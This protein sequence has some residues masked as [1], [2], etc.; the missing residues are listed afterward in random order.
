MDLASLSWTELHCLLPSL[1]HSTKEGSAARLAVRASALSA[2]CTCLRLRLWSCMRAG[3]SAPVAACASGRPCVLIVWP[4][5]LP[6]PP[7][8]PPPPPPPPLPRALSPLASPWTHPLA[9][10]PPPPLATEASDP[11]CRSDD[12]GAVSSLASHGDIGRAGRALIRIAVSFIAVFF[13]ARSAASRRQVQQALHGGTPGRRH[14]LAPPDGS[15][16][17][18]AWAAALREPAQSTAQRRGRTGLH[19]TICRRRDEANAGEL[20]CRQPPLL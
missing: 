14:R 6:L 5:P 13:A 4:A 12:S 17:V 9:V 1:R 3:T 11:G 15:M 16:S 7:L 20:R 8:P 18:A 2:V 19:M 10:A